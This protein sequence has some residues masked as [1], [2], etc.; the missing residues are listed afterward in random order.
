M[1]ITPAPELRPAAGRRA[2]V[3][4]CAVAVIGAG[5]YGLSAS[6]HLQSVG[7]DVRSFGTPMDSWIRHMPAGMKLRSLWTASN[8]ADPDHALG[9][10][11]YE[12]QAG[13][14]RQEPIP[15]ER[16]IDY[17]LWFQR[18][19]VPGLDPRSVSFVEPGS[20]GF[21]LRLEDGEELQADRVVV[22]AGITPFAFRPPAFAG[23]PAEL[24]P[25]A[26]D[27]DD[28]SVFSG[29]R[30]VVV[31]GGQ[32]AT[33][34]AALLHEAGAQVELISYKPSVRWL[35]EGTGPQGFKASWQ[36][37]AWRRVAIGGPR[38]SWVAALPGLT[39]WVPR[40]MRMRLGDRV[41]GPAAAGWL[42]A[43]LA[44]VPITTGRS[45][46]RSG[47]LGDS[48]LLTLD[49]GS[50]REVDH[51]LLATGYR[52]DVSRYPFLAPSIVEQLRTWEGY[53]ELRGGLESSVRGL[54]FLGSPAMASYG[55]VFRFVAGTW[56]SARGLTHAVTGKGRRAGFSW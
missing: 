42:R 19:A 53:P 25:H 45:I 49:D 34:S 14:A 17:G 7:A 18:T 27:H 11:R 33:E 36:L 35:A 47:R 10:G 29:R 21:N 8:I 23:L 1:T 44:D 3:A 54:H 13:L 46:V 4:R 32:S 37:Y 2:A 15:V 51:V 24:A 41:A 43:R 16:F 40:D 39:R 22:A 55:P 6:A 52:V 9:I 56:A 48:V 5:P 31:G 38:G 12:G 28:L 50:E 26:A 20:S 30:M